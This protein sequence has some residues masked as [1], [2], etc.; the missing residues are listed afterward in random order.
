MN[1][2]TEKEIVEAAQRG[3]T[4]SLGLLYERYF[5]AMA[6]LAYSVVLDRDLAQDI[7]QDTFA[8]VCRKLGKL[9]RPERFAGWL[10]RICRNLAVDALRQNRAN[11]VSLDESN[12]PAPPGHEDNGQAVHEAIGR[13]PQMYREIVILFYFH[14]MS[15]EDI[16]GVL[17]ISLHTVKGRLCRARK[18]IGRI[19]KDN[20][21][22]D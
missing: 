18:Q 20:G 11:I 21:F 8:Q 6:W 3:D 15:Y 17:G 7:A 1:Q 2:R 9:R 14:N 4:E 5:K 19:L 16:Q 10:A 12:E 22:D 13:L